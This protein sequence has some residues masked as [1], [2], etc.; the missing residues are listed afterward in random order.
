M[1]LV[2]SGYPALNDKVLVW[3][4]ST[5]VPN[6]INRFEVFGRIFRDFFSLQIT[7]DNLI[8]INKIFI[9][10]NVRDFDFKDLLGSTQG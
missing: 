2:T 4:M 6:I 10:Q 8:R 5:Y 9:L 7:S 3:G 1:I